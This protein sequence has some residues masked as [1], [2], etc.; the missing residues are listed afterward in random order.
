MATGLALALVAGAL[1]W[2]HVG[3]PSGKQGGVEPHCEA[4]RKFAARELSGPG[5][6]LVAEGTAVALPADRQKMLR[7][8]VAVNGTYIFHPQFKAY[9]Y[10]EM[11]P[12]PWDTY[13]LLRRGPVVRVRCAQ[14]G[15]SGPD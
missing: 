2:R 5:A 7:E 6:P 15:E 11:P 1:A 9:G 4:F 13:T 14:H 3:A 8:T 10:R 12:C